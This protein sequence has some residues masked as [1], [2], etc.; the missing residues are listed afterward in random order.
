MNRPIAVAPDT[1]PVMYEA[2]CRAVSAAGASLV[3]PREA[4]GLIWADP[5]RT[6]EFPE[7]VADAERL[8]WIQLPG[9]PRVSPDQALGL[10][11]FHQRGARR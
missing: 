8:S 9:S 2:M 5:G 1:R 6:E 3:E 4:E 10:P 7:I 11:G